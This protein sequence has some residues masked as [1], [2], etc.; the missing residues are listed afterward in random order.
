[1][2]TAVPPST[3]VLTA[4]RRHSSSSHTSSDSGTPLLVNPNTGET[5]RGKPSGPGSTFVDARTLPLSEIQR[6]AAELEARGE[7]EKA[8]TLQAYYTGAA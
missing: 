4:H 5:R 7:T 2:I 3:A 8:K 6:I 1:M